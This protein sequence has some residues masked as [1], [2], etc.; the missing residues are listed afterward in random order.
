MGSL[1]APPL[2]D[3]S[4]RVKARRCRAAAGPRRIDARAGRVASCKVLFVS[5]RE[6]AF[7]FGT[8]GL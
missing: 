3:S 2:R 4:H 5:G 8:P 7:P 1:L 6:W